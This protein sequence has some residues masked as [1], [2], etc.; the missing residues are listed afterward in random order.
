MG[1]FLEDLAN[2][3]VQSPPSIKTPSVDDVV[4]A[5]INYMSAG[6]VGYKDGKFDPKK[7][8]LT[9]AIDEGVGEVTGRNM[10][11]EQTAIARQKL[12]EEARQ[13]EQERANELIRRQQEDTAASNYAA[14]ARA[15]AEAQTNASFGF[16]NF[17]TDFLG[18]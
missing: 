18:L 13:K 8:Y 1:N 15:T 3:Q 16:G 11:R 6:L 4:D 7:G 12:E 5:A 14:A 17:S 2:G 9:R 10:A